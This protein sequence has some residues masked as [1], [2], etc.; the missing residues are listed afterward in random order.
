[1]KT[2]SKC[3]EEKSIENFQQIVK[4]GRIYHRGAC[5]SCRYKMRRWYYENNPEVWERRK[6][7]ENKQR[8]AA[9]QDKTTRAKFIVRDAKGSDRKKGFDNDLTIEFVQAL[10]QNGCAYC[11]SQ[12]KLSL[13]RIDNTIGHTQNNVQ[14]CCW[15][16]NYIRRDMPW[17]AWKIVSKAV[18]EATERGLLQNWRAGGRC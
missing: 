1:M 10:I 18:K 11:T 5:E 15:S 4:K 8:Q 7:I 6:A 16:C 3:K 17:E 14:P 2:C 13:D 9:R 12:E